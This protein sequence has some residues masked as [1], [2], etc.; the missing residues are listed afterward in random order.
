MAEVMN[1]S[2]AEI[3]PSTS[4]TTC[5]SVS[6]DR[7][8]KTSST[9]SSTPPGHVHVDAAKVGG[10]REATMCEM[11]NCSSRREQ[12]LLTRVR[13]VDVL[14]DPRLNKVGPRPFFYSA[15][16]TARYLN[17]PISPYRVGIQEGLC[18][19]VVIRPAASAKGPWFNSPVAR[20]YLRFNSRTSTPAGKR[21]LAVR[22]TVAHKM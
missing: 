14:R 10:G 17:Y 19:L 21:C 9:S 3:S 8:W 1:G 4:S 13:G 7:K 18:G 15:S 20:T 6:M 12:I 2:P 16:A 22:C 11:K 5:E